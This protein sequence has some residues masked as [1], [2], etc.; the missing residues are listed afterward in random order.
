M[1]DDKKNHIVTL[2]A[3]KFVN[4]YND[5]ENFDVTEENEKEREN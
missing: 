2:S 5:P 3:N 4:G 1:Y